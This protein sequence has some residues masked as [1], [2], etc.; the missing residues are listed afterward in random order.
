[1]QQLAQ[2]FPDQVLEL[3]GKGLLAGIKI[4]SPVRDVMARLRDDHHVLAMTAGENVLRLLPPLIVTEAEIDEAVGK[5]AAVFEAIENETQ[6]QP[7]T[8]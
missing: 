2:R 3:R 5:I 6:A 1:L 4:A 8:V 7:A